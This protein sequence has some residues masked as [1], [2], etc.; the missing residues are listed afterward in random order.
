MM[1]ITCFYL[2]LG[3]NNLKIYFNQNMQINTEYSSYFKWTRTG[4]VTGLDII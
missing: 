2:L 1:N 4:S 3:G